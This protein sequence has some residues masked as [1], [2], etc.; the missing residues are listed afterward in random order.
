MVRNVQI[1]VIALGK[2]LSDNSS[3]ITLSI[4]S[5]NLHILSLYTLCAEL[6]TTL[7][8]YWSLHVLYPLLWTLFG[9]LF[10]PSCLSILYLVNDKDFNDKR[11]H[12]K[13]VHANYRYGANCGCKIKYSRYRQTLAP[14]GKECSDTGYSF[15]EILR[16]SSYRIVAVVRL[17]SVLSLVVPFSIH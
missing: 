10:W 3:Y 1:L 5:N 17:L 8:V 2:I 13:Y 4:C 7:L 16:T 14:H 15:R 12:K 6:S 11:G 9:Y